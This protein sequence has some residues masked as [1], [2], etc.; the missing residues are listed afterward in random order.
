VVANSLGFS[1]R[2]D[3]YLCDVDS[4][5]GVDMNKERE[6]LRRVLDYIDQYDSQGL[7]LYGEIETYLSTHSDDAEEPVKCKRCNGTGVVD[8][9]WIDCYPD[10]T[11]YVNAPI[12]CVKD[13]PDC[14]CILP[15]RLMECPECEHIFEKTAKEEEE[16]LI[17]E[18]SKLNYQQIKDEVK[19]ADFKKLEQIALAKGYRAN[20]IYH[21]L[22]TEDDIIKYAEF[23]GYH[24]KWVNYQ[25]QLREKN[26]R[27]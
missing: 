2:T 5:A 25:L 19:T 23:K 24:K 8:D 1:V 6:L 18:L 16:D 3:A 4:E 7:E 21:H 13:C 17:V 22:K 14:G 26:E 27:K 12:K 20:W 10:G 11:P 15:A 9:G